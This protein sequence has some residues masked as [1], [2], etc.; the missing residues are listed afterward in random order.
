MFLKGKKM[1]PRQKFDSFPYDPLFRK[2]GYPESRRRKG[3]E[4]RG[5]R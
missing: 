2:W 5:E 1:T 3:T 4:R